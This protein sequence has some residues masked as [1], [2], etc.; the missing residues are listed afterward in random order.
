MCLTKYNFELKIPA[1]ILPRY[2]V[3]DRIVYFNADSKLLN[4]EQKRFTWIISNILLEIF[5]DLF[6]KN[7]F[8]RIFYIKLNL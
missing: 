5:K 1:G 4:Y 3:H 2:F 6:F 7:P 8:I